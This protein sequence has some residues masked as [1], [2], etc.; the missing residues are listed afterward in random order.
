MKISR[1]EN[2]QLTNDD[3]FRRI[4]RE[5]EEVFSM[6]DVGAN[7]CGKVSHYACRDVRIVVDRLPDLGQKMSQV[8][9]RILYRPVPR[10]GNKTFPELGTKRSQVPR[11]A[12]HNRPRWMRFGR[13]VVVVKYVST[14][15][16]QFPTLTSKGLYLRA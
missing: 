3:N 4:V 12:D 13:P 2:L 8:L 16:A 14:A 11:A 15:S 9:I 6:A 5:E 7:I 10:V 1:E